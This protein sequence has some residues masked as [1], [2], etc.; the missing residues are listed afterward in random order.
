MKKYYFL[1]IIAFMASMIILM[2][3]FIDIFGD[4]NETTGGK[5]WIKNNFLSYF[6]DSCLVLVGFI[7]AFTCIKKIESF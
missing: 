6:L 2:I 1:W 7:S 5:I 4:P 3:P